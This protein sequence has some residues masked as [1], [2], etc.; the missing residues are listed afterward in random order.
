MKANFVVAKS[1]IEEGDPKLDQLFSMMIVNEK[2][3]NGDAVNYQATSSIFDGKDSL[4]F[5]IGYKDGA[6]EA[7]PAEKELPAGWLYL[8]RKGGRFG[9]K[10][11]NTEQ[12]TK[13]P[14]KLSGY[15]DLKYHEL[16]AQAKEKG[17]DPK[18]HA[19][20]KKNTLINFLEKEPEEEPEI[21]INEI[22]F[23]EVQVDNKVK[24]A[25]GYLNIGAVIGDNK[26]FEHSFTEMLENGWIKPVE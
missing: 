24:N 13:E 23:F 7:F 12:K 25:T 4:N 17:F 16:L 5:V 22:N 3:E 19:D 2:T 18:E 14:E 10:I 26:E 8:N 9:A 11:Q 15:E 1:F 21:D 20:K 6:F